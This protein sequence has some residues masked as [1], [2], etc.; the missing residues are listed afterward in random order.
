MC[1]AD[2][3]HDTYL[4]QR[5]QRQKSVAYKPNALFAYWLLTI[6]KNTFVWAEGIALPFLLWTFVKQ[7][8]HSEL[9]LPGLWAQ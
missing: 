5:F 6:P 7:Y 3:P 8:T 1:K 2:T 4:I 9:T